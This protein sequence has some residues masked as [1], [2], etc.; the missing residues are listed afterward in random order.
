MLRKRIGS[1]WCAFGLCLDCGKKG[2]MWVQYPTKLSA[3]DKMRQ[4]V[5]VAQTEIEIMEELREK[6]PA[7]N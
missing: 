1:E 2:H 5:V 4:L 6:K 7:R 3:D